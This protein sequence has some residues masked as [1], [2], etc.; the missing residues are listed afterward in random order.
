[1]G[2][3]ASLKDSFGGTTLRATVFYSPGGITPQDTDSAYS[4]SRSGA[5]ANYTYGKL[6]L[7][8]TTG[9]PFDFSLVNLFTGQISDANLL[10]SEQLGFGGYDTIRGYDT[11]VVNADQ[12]LIFS[13]ELHTPPT[14]LLSQLGWKKH[15]TDN[16]QF[17]GFVDYGL[18]ADKHRLPQ[19][20]RT[21]TLLGA[22]PG[23]RYSLAS[24]LTVRADYGWRLRNVPTDRI[25][26]MRWHVGMVLS[27]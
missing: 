3:N 5:A 2:Y 27:Y 23:V 19:E 1:L 9:M 15:P 8:R 13:N 4:L 14:S 6:E 21:T 10:G 22:G 17:I 7:S 18:A 20:D 25:N 24:C 16:L 26:S 11:R 12:G